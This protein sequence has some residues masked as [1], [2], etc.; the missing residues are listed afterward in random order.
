MAAAR[1]RTIRIE[2]ML[3][4]NEPLLRPHVAHATRFIHVVWLIGILI[5]ATLLRVHALGR[6]SYWYDELAS[7][8]YANGRT[9][10]IFQVPLGYFDHAPAIASKPGMR[11]WKNV[12]FGFDTT[13]PLY[14]TLL[15]IWWRIFG[16]SDVAGRSLSVALS[17]LTIVALYD[18]GCLV[19]APV[20]SLWACA[21]CAASPPMVRYAQE[22][23]SY[24][25]LGL[26]GVLM[27]GI[28]LRIVR[29]GGAGRRYALLWLLC[30]AALLTHHFIAGGVASIAVF[31][32]IRL[33]GRPRIAMVCVVMASFIVELWEVPILFHHVQNL[34]LGIDWLEEDRV[35]F[36]KTLYR[37]VWLPVVYLIFPADDPD[38]AC[39][40]AIVLLALPLLLR[41]IRPDLLLA[42]LWP[43]GIIGLVAASDL[44]LGHGALLYVR[45]TLAAAPMVFI[46]FAAIA[47]LGGRWMRHLLPALAVAGA[48]LAVPDIY[49]AQTWIKPE[50]RQLVADIQS[51]VKPGDVLVIA[52][53]PKM[54][55]A[56]AGKLYLGIDFYAG[57][58]PYPVAILEV[59]TD[60][61]VRR[62]IWSHNDVWLIRCFDGMT[63]A[64]EI[65]PD[66]YLGPCRLIPAGGTH[67]FA[68]RLFL[69]KPAE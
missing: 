22:A 64:S 35:G 43:I 68:G 21:L 32:I 55:L 19:M 51:H 13:P 14:P 41:K 63:S 1:V 8:L 28:A 16:E 9:P 57:P 11:S 50:T 42:G 44:W 34:Q 25:L 47:D 65:N 53:R 29:F 23:R 56:S 18:V 27:C 58:L 5:G 60:Q 33:R 2:N 69:A 61:A 46:S 20:P 59:P 26:L 10:A 45:Y 67:L 24:A 17:L 38:L 4:Q 39:I 37:I 36:F 40:P 3:R 6:T 48:L 52:S 31:A 12:W 54:G 66:E 49:S 62:E 7:V 30:G 15:R